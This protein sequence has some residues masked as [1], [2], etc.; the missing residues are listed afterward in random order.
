[1]ATLQELTKLMGEAVSSNDITKMLEVAGDIKKLKA[2]VAKAEA[3]RLE[4]EANEL[5]DVRKAAVEKLEKTFRPTDK[6][7]A[8][9]LATMAEIKA[10]GFHYLYIAEG[11]QTQIGYDFPSVKT[12]TKHSGGGGQSG[13]SKAEFGLSLSEIVEKFATEAEKKAIEAEPDN[14]KSW[15]LKN[16]VKKQAIA[17]GKLKPVS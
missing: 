7:Y 6:V 8:S 15:A 3:E 13:K 11:N 2:E 10:I 9:I 14:S 17:D 16:K 12:A 1:M 5:A 4:K